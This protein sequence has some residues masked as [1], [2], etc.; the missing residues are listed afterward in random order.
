MALYEA[1]S[2]SYDSLNNAIS[3]ISIALFLKLALSK[4]KIQ[5]KE[6]T[7]LSISLICLVLTKQVY[8]LIALLFFIIPKYKF[9][10]MKK[11]IIY[12]I[13]IVL[14]ASII[15]IFWEYLFTNN[16]LNNTLSHSSNSFLINQ[17]NFLTA[18]KNSLMMESGFYVQNF[19]SWCPIGYINLPNPV[20]LF[21]TY[22]Y[23][24]I[25]IIVSIL[26]IS[27]FKLKL[28]QKT[29]PLMIFSVLSILIFFMAFGWTPPGVGFISAMQGRYFI[30][31]APLFFLIFYNNGKITK[32]LDKKYLNYLN[33]FVITS[34]V[35]M[36]SISTYISYETSL[37]SM[38]IN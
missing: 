35:I 12:F 14:P 22:I 36:L 16:T 6:I 29:I 34:I 31:I 8:F 25:L 30:P 20:P 33:V 11:R 18:L 32:Y 3:F 13:Y 10:N 7:L 15:M 21:L 17:I 28:K 38:F 23:L 37:L 2:L 27:K 4:N 1:A 24:I 5:K 26:D 9:G 19:I